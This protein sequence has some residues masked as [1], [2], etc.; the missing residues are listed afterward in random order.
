[1]LLRAAKNPQKTRQIDPPGHL[2]QYPCVAKATLEVIDVLR[3]SAAKLRGGSDYSWGH[4]GQCNCGHLSQVVT[5]KSSGEIHKMAL[6]MG[7]DWTERVNGYC[8]TSGMA[9]DSLI[10]QLVQLGFNVN[11][12]ADLESLSDDRILRTLPEDRRW[13]SHNVREDVIEY[14]EAWAVLL[15]AERVRKLEEH[16]LQ[17]VGVDAAAAAE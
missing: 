16:S 12:L 8:P 5:G 4:L 9:I 1:M 15:D 3:R 2:R 10:R 14:L 7:G 17:R 13:L 11:D 6:E